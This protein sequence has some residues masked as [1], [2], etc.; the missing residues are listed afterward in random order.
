MSP[1]D[2]DSCHM[3]LVRHGA[4]SS[5][6]SQPT[7]LQGNAVDGPLAE[8]GQSQARQTAEFLARFPMDVVFSS[9]MLRARQTAGLIAAC[10]GLSAIEV[11][12]IHEADVGRWVHRDWGDIAASEPELYRL[13]MENP[14]EHGYP[15]GENATDV[16]NRAVPT[17]KRLM[18]E[19][20]G[21]RIVAVAHN[22][23]NRVMVAHLLKLPLSE[24]RSIRQDNCC[25]N[26]IQLRADR[27]ELITAN[28]IFH[29]HD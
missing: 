14:A 24:M 4:T 23:V 20:L 17:L 21:R 25:I 1:L 6:L 15:D 8:L 28:S 10:H 16:A 3:F 7:V 19:N 22:I 18:Q 5:N 27:F 13:H 29:L 2:P 26:W 9:P 12:E 11:P